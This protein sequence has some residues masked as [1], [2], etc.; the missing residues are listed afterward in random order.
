MRAGILLVTVCFLLLAEWTIRDARRKDAD[1]AAVKLVE[2]ARRLGEATDEQRFFVGL[3]QDPEFGRKATLHHALEI[4][5]GR[6]VPPGTDARVSGAHLWE[7]DGDGR[8]LTPG[9]PASQ[10]ADLEAIWNGVILKTWQNHR[11]TMTD[12]ENEAMWAALKTAQRL[13]SPFIDLPDIW[14][15]STFALRVTDGAGRGLRIGLL[16]KDIEWSRNRGGWLGCFP[17]DALDP[18]FQERRI[19]AV[20]GYTGIDFCAIQQGGRL[21]I[22]RSHLLQGRSWRSLGLNPDAAR[23]RTVREGHFMAFRLPAGRTL[24]IGCR[25]G[26]AY[27]LPGWLRWG[28]AL[29]CLVFAWKGGTSLAI[30][31]TASQDTGLGLRALVLAMF[32][33][34]S[35]VPLGAILGFVLAAMTEAGIS[36]RRFWGSVLERRV[37]SAD[38]NLRNHVES[39]QIE[40]AS[41]SRSLAAAAVEDDRTRL[42]ELLNI[43]QHGFFGICF[44]ADGKAWQKQVGRHVTKQFVDGV[45]KIG[46]LVFLRIV[47]E[48]RG[49]AEGV[50]ASGTRAIRLDATD[51][52]GNGHPMLHMLQMPGMIVQGD[53][54][55]RTSLIYWSLLR[56]RPGKTVGASFVNLLIDDEIVRFGKRLAAMAEPGDVILRLMYNSMLCPD[57]SGNSEGLVRLSIDALR[58]QGDSEGVVDVGGVPML[59]VANPSSIVPGACLLSWI[60]FERVR[61]SLRHQSWSILGSLLAALVPVAGVALIL[62]RRIAGPIDALTRAGRRVTAGCDPA[63]LPVEGPTELAELA[64]S[65]NEMA[66]GLR[67]R[68]R[69][70]RYLSSAAWEA[71]FG[72][73]SADRITV[74][75]LSSD[76]RGFTSLSERYAAG[77]IVA[78][79]NDYFTC[80]ERV[81]RR[82]G[83]DV[84]RFVGDAVTAVFRPAPGEVEAEGC[85]RAL[86]AA[87]EM[88]A[89]LAGFNA[90]RAAAGWFTIENGIGIDVGPAVCGL[91]GAADGRRDVTVVGPVVARA[92]ECEAASRFGTATRIVATERVVRIMGP[93]F[94]WHRLS[95]PGS[96]A[97]ACH[98][99]EGPA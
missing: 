95:L 56:D 98:E 27:A 19:A 96:P 43:E 5:L 99:W 78:M 48:A 2:A 4:A 58:S 37:E 85:R 84:D 42:Q 88:R 59:T 23:I 73:R 82:H 26:W 61:T 6:K 8:L 46:N 15:A 44:T 47:E 1:E 93:E 76:I 31:L 64:A 86:R 51:V 33:L 67:Q 25:T 97:G 71:A 24:G 55:G 63:L 34:A 65:F 16:R 68:E 30:A 94:R 70:R 57:N 28:A 89:A 41:M 14:H 81:I 13:F 32:F 91:V 60:P 36:A 83:G 69:M 20:L 53:L 11:Q 18:L 21:T 45:R 50:E 52:I 22:P 92:A 29:A 87:A 90:A 40:M 49:D 38:R 80:M 72:G 10:A 3:A 9:Y 17:T 35:L 74:A 62:N 66:E 75:V 12:A 7:F 54:Y 79:L 77:E 39:M